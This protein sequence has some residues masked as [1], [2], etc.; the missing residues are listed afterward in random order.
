MNRIG[1]AT[2]PQLGVDERV[3][4][5]RPAGAHREV[6]WENIARRKAGMSIAVRTTSR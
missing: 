4:G 2:P 3:F 5:P 1:S 6:R